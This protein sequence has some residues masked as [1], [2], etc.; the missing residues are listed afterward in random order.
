[1]ILYFKY[2]SLSGESKRSYKLINGVPAIQAPVL[3]KWYLVFL[4]MT[5]KKEMGAAVFNYQIN[6]D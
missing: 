2:S 1:M 4:L 3:G 5:M 6:P